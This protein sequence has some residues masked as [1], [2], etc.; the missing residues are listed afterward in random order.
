MP[1]LKAKLF[2][3]ADTINIER[4]LP[5]AQS[6][7]RLS[8]IKLASVVQQW[9][10]DSIQNID[11]TMRQTLAN[12]QMPPA[13]KGSIV[14]IAVGSRGIDR[15][16]PVVIHCVDFL[17]SSGFDPVI[18]PAMGSHG[19]GNEN[20]QKEVLASFGISEKTLNV[21]VLANMDTI[22][23][24]AISPDFPVFFAKTAIE[25]D[26]LVIINRIKS[27][28]KF[29]GP[30]ESGLSKMLSIGL[31]KA[32]GAGFYHQKAVSDGFFWI[33]DIAQMIINDYS[34]IFGLA[35]IENQHGQLSHIEAIPGKKIISREKEL[36]LRSK[37]L[38][39]SI[40]F[41]QIDILMID[42]IGKNIS[43]IGMDSNVTGRHR[44]IVGNI[45][46]R[47]HVKRIYVRNLSK[48]TY[49][50]ANGIG[51]A[52]VINK[53]CLD[54]IDLQATYM[55]A[56]TALSPEKAGIPIFFDT[57][58]QCLA[59]CLH[60]SGKVSGRSTRLVWIKNTGNLQRF[61]VSEGL[62]LDIE[63]NPSLSQMTDWSPIS[64]DAHGTI[65]D[66]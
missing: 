1:Q 45:F 58:Q 36:L 32:T 57:D 24:G 9:P 65:L 13:Q 35:L 56:L 59:A 37:R 7:Q 6:I 48:K 34:I 51:L 20:G 39:P 2:Q 29:S 33:E 21:P 19:G 52:D 12:I 22:Q 54:A 38:M 23:I 60:T 50:N 53:R 3:K 4:L 14:G 63:Q 44:D 42:E 41:D 27:H 26:H 8:E 49:G 25:V 10:S 40:P 17:K 5:I 30:I 55:N 64:F 47:P 43:G 62:K 66:Y 15:L 46:D 11:D 61:K 18:I 31:G 16:A 28:T